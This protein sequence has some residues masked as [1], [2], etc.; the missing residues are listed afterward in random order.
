MS[1][2][3]R[4]HEILSPYF[5][6][7]VTDYVCTTLTNYQINFFVTKPRKT[8][9]GDYRINRKKNSFTI[10][11][12]ENLNPVQ[13]LITALH[14]LAHHSTWLKHKNQVKPHG[15]EW[16]QEYQRIF[17]PILT[18]SNV[19]ET[20]KRVLAVHLKNPKATSYSDKHLNNYLNTTFGEGIKRVLDIPLNEP[21]TLGKRTFIKEK[22][23]RTR[24][25]CLDTSNQKK[26]LIHEHTELH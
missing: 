20:L 12:N 11:V 24:Y 10:T 17:M 14:E 8:K 26:Y 21:F 4:I 9:L 6:S 1:D 23:L 7:S 13:F 5:H 19:D 16:Q 25:L 2:K 15:K 18:N 3:T 22:K